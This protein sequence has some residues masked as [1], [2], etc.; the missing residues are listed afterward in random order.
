[1]PTY[2]NYEEL[3]LKII[4]NTKDL[5]YKEFL[6]TQIEKVKKMDLTKVELPKITIGG[7]LS[8]YES[9]NIRW[10]PLKNDSGDIIRWI[11]IE[12]D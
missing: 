11:K 5:K 2:L 3:N 4:N 8:D 7:K 6:I 1:M 12:D 10:F 9:M